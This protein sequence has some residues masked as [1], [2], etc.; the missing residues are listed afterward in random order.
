MTSQ[1]SANTPYN[2]NELIQQ[3]PNELNVRIMN[4]YSARLT[5]EE[6]W[7]LHANNDIT[8]HFGIKDRHYYVGQWTPQKDF[9]ELERKDIFRMVKMLSINPERCRH[10]IPETP[11]PP[12][13][14]WKRLSFL[15]NGDTTHLEN[16]INQYKEAFNTIKTHFTPTTPLELRNRNWC[17]VNLT[18]FS[19][20]LAAKIK[21]LQPESFEQRWAKLNITNP[22]L[23]GIYK[24]ILW[25]DKRTFGSFHKPQPYIVPIDSRDLK[26]TSFFPL[27]IGKVQESNCMY[28]VVLT[29]RVYVPFDLI[30]NQYGY[31]KF[32][33]D[34]VVIWFTNNSNCPNKNSYDHLLSESPYHSDIHNI[35]F[36]D[37]S[38]ADQ[39]DQLVVKLNL[40]NDT[41][42]SNRSLSLAI[43][44]I[45]IE[46]FYRNP[47]YPTIQFDTSRNQAAVLSVSVINRNKFVKIRNTPTQE[48]YNQIQTQAQYNLCRL[49]ASALCLV[50]LHRTTNA[51]TL[52]PASQ[53][54]GGIY[55]YLEK[56]DIE[57]EQAIR[58]DR[59]KDTPWKT[60]ITES[61]ILYGK[62]PVFPFENKGVAAPPPTQLL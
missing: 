33:H 54:Y 31:C 4:F 30:K 42:P 35:E 24:I 14:F 10:K 9:T 60:I 2:V 29:N 39:N 47:V 25:L 49:E 59:D 51:D 41:E 28:N 56:E 62:G 48:T 15:V 38:I 50:L 6:G 55:Y 36:K 26:A 22:L 57:N 44:Q 8:E 7:E 34:N 46:T 61:P 37:Y 40:P 12:T 43:V 21:G 16:R 19:Q 5:E 17:L 27:E 23:K 11:P 1:V 32:S 45:A 20:E 52:F 13:T 18:L 3:L 53:N 58:I